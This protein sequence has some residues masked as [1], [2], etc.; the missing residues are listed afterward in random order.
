MNITGPQAAFY[1]HVYGVQ[2]SI[3]DVFTFYDREL[4][5]GTAARTGSP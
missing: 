4:G 5:R 1:G 2:S 3:D